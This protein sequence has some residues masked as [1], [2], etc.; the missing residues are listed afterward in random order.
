MGFVYFSI[1]VVS[2]YYLMQY[3]NN[4]AERNLKDMKEHVEVLPETKLQNEAFQGMVK[5]WKAKK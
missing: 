3:V 1:P 4:V 2:G 5:E